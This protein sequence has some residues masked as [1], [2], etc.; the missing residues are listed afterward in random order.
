GWLELH[1][2]DAPALVLT[3]ID[4][5]SVPEAPGADPFLPDRLRARLGLPDDRFRHGRDAYLLEASLRP[6][7]EVHVVV[8]RESAG[9]DP[10]RPSRLLLAAY[11]EDL[12]RRVTRLF[13]EREG[14]EET[15]APPAAGRAAE[16]GDGGGEGDGA[17]GA[18]SPAERGGFRSPPEPEIR[19]DEV[20]DRLRVNDFRNLLEDPYRF[21]L[22][23]LLGLEARGDRD[24]ELGPPGF[25]ALA[26]GVLHRFGESDASA[27]A[28]AER[29]EDALL[30]LLEEERRRRY[31]DD[32]YP[33]VR[34]QVEQLRLRLRHFARWQARRAR[35]GWRIAAVEASPEGGEVAFE[36]DGEPVW[37]RGRVD[38]IDVHEER[39]E[40]QLLD[41]KTGERPES[42]EKS[43]RAG[44]RG[45]RR[46][47]DLQLPLYRH[48]L[49]GIARR[50]DVPDALGRVREPGLGFVHVS[51]GGVE[52]SLADWSEELLREADEAAREA[53]R[54][55]REGIFRHDP[56]RRRTF[57]GDPL[58]PLFEAEDRTGAAAGAEA[59]PGADDR[60][61][62][63]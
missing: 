59:D 41:Y 44:R 61:E 35:E 33:A 47:V 40:W 14:G 50:E 43:H 42:P 60:E 22:E 55:M 21:A 46:W 30:G 10:L 18:T 58:D 56:A 8:G 28:D 49:A 24:R 48:L 15:G 37:L 53:V 4:D 63:P 13:G 38:R 51:G 9:G 39:G 26:H 12:A 1:L 23:R 31:G 54:R 5:A 29:I 19:V 32:T 62:E 25:G 3:G 17:A 11:G 45:D 27:S 34:L 16:A 52:L 36:V 7:E 57:R 6:R 2:D 20:P